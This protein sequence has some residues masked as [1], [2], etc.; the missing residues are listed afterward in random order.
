[1]FIRARV[2]TA[3][4]R[5]G[6]VALAA[7][8]LCAF[9][10]AHAETSA[11]SPVAQD[12]VRSAV[13]LAL[14]AN[15]GDEGALLRADDPRA[16]TAADFDS[17]GLPDLAAG[18]GA[19][20]GG[21]IVVAAGNPDAIYPNT[22]EAK[23]RRE[24]GS[25]IAAPFYPAHVTLWIPLAPDFLL[26]GDFDADGDQDLLAFARGGDQAA[27]LAGDGRGDFSPA[28]VLGLPGRV[29]AAITADVNRRDGMADV[30]LGLETQ[31]GPALLVAEGPAGA[32]RPMSERFL[33]AA[34]IQAI[35]AGYFDDDPWVDIAVGSGAELWIVR[36][37]DR[38]LS[39]DDGERAAVPA[40]RL[41]W[42]ATP[43]GIT[44][45][46]AGDWSGGFHDLA[47]LGGDGR[48]RFLARAALA[49]LTARGRRGGVRARD[50]GAR[51]RR[52][53]LA[54]GT[55]RHRQRGR[56]RRARPRRRP[57]AAVRSG[58]RPTTPTRRRRSS[59]RP[60]RPGSASPW[61]RSPCG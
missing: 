48:A 56:P 29:T 23:A 60:T 46:A 6:F 39:Q 57:P 15:A 21:A 7:A 41:D 17:D 10:S 5:V 30:L 22:A 47:I 35:A 53:H 2:G 58:G 26:S 20:S 18:F 28:A 44:A 43:A 27:F 3:A 12:P 52:R 1:M 54:A 13:P 50:R 42:L 55:H 36:G 51:R 25:A 37:R 19:A 59:R 9:T 33:L 4:R 31:D 38:R 49:Q 14:L 8:A 45:L 11:E 40:A 61:R 34:P 32:I 24:D 16:L